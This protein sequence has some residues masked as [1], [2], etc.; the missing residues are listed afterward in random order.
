MKAQCSMEVSTKATEFVAL[1]DALTHN[2]PN[3]RANAGKVEEA[4][5]LVQTQPK[6]KKK[7]VHLN[8]LSPHTL[9]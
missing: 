8:K 3:I 9:I 7:Y 2:A 5:N 1:A 4:P 6:K